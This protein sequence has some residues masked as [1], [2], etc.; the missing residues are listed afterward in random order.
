MTKRLQPSRAPS[1]VAWRSCLSDRRGVAAVEFALL[2]PVVTTLLI[3]LV[4]FGQVIYQSM[5]VQVAAH[6]GAD[7]AMLNGWNS[8]G[9]TS[10]V[11]GAT[12]MTINASPAPALV[13]ACV[14]NG[15]ITTTTDATCP[16]GS[17]QT[18]PGTYVEVYS[19]ATFT[20][21]IPWSIFG[22]PT[23]LAAQA[24]VRVG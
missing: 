15:V 20:P 24:M 9:V 6:A 22:L 14:V 11:T 8:S 19:Q 5:E 7:Y 4:D 23:S 21:L 1:S 18:T 3:G 17:S 13:S 10:A 16:T 2:A 12:S